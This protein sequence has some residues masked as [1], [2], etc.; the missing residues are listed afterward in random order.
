MCGKASKIEQK[1]VGPWSSQK[2]LLAGMTFLSRLE[3]GEGHG[4]SGWPIPVGK[5]IST[6]SSWSCARWPFPTKGT[7]SS[8]RR[9]F[10][11]GEFG[12]LSTLCTLAT[13]PT[14][15]P[16]TALLE[17]SPRPK[18]RPACPR[19]KA[20]PACRNWNSAWPRKQRKRLQQRP[21]RIETKMISTL[22]DHLGLTV[23]ELSVMMGILYI[24][25]V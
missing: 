13:S 6:N 16:D 25:T 21:S 5:L 12:G 24:F 1:T 23:L 9:S 10:C 11:E 7:P 3:L 15:W 19:P 8:G 20:S 22:K 14:L 2:D 18:G 4:H 17:G